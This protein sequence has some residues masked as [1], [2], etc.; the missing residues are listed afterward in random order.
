MIK[1][2]LVLCGVLVMIASPVIAGGE[3]VE[4]IY[5]DIEQVQEDV[6]VLKSTNDM[7]NEAIFGLGTEVTRLD[8]EK[9][10]KI[11]DSSYY[12]GVFG[13]ASIFA[14][15]DPSF[16]TGWVAGAFGGVEM[17]SFRG[18]LEY[19]Y[20][21]S[22][23]KDLDSDISVNSLMGN[24]YFDFEA[25]GM[26]TPY[27]TT[28]LGVGWWDMGNVDVDKTTVV[29]KFGGGVDVNVAEDMTVGARYVYFSA[30][31]NDVDYDTSV[32][33]GVFTMSF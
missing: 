9:Q 33:T 15:G 23:F 32:I 14:G 19:Q 20:L 3:K 21:K 18:E 24:L 12:A 28:G 27:L 1:K 13:G 4:G 11:N 29:S 16:D 8:A 2:I 17:S 6:D 22:D 10:D 30:L 31:D 25:W 5:T 7:Q 26:V